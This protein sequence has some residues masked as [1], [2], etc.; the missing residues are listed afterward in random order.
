MANIKKFNVPNGLSTGSGDGLRE[1][2]DKEGNVYIPES[3]LDELNSSGL[4][5]Q[6]LSSTGTGAKWKYPIVTNVL[7][8]TKDGND[9]NSGTSLQNAKATIKS[10]LEVATSGTLIKVSAGNYAED[11][12]LIIPEQVSII[13]DSLREVSV[14]PLNPADLFY[15]N[16]GS[17]ISDM[18]FVSSLPNSYAIFAFNPNDPPYINQ[19]PYI[20][21]CTNFI[22]GS[23][24]L[25]VDGAHCLGQLKSMVVDS[26]T[27]YNQDG[28]GAQ[29]LNEGYAQLVSMFTICCDKAIECLSGGGCDLTNSN[30]S[31]GNYGLIADGVSELKYTGTVVDNQSE[32]N[33][34]IN[35]NIASVAT[36]IVDAIYAKE[37]GLLT[38]T[39]AIDH[40]LQ[41]GMD[42]ELRDLTFNCTS[43][44]STSSQDFPSGAYGYEF[45]VYSVI[46]PTEFT[47]RV[48]KSDIDHSYVPNTGNVKLKKIKPFDGQSLYINDLYYQVD[49]INISYGGSGYTA[50]PTIT[51]SPPE[52]T[53]GITATAIAEISNGEIV[54]I[55]TLSSGRGYSSTPPQI[56]IDPP[57]DGDGPIVAITMSPSYFLVAGSTEISEDNYSVTLK[58]EIPFAVSENDLV[59]VHKQTRLLAS[60]HSFEYV[61]SG[62]T[63]DT[64]LPRNGGESIQ[65]NEITMS[66][67]GSV[68]YT[69]TDQS[70]NF[71]IGD[72]VV[73]DQALGLISGDAYNRSL[74]S[75]V[76]PFIL[77]LGA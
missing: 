57:E 7:F 35:V 53:W 3:L 36:N 21:N 73:I 42:I 15:V 63:I 37:T 46:S 76:T 45:R 54:S 24:G 23:I 11:N 66:N 39:T 60:G 5:G 31:M 19:S 56:T 64:A 51:I 22:R 58:D 12:P 27:Q 55:S 14:S 10:A 34:S 30:S 9:S 1:I 13:G 32:E 40:N 52:E 48:G 72:G 4:P 65:E 49:K 59:Y 62:T 43:N 70:G 25:R 6:F 8:V 47:V 61:G 41:E 2:I 44:G 77:A 67:G 18:S 75:S 28:I 33:N 20:Q 38:V 68:I 74:F 17:Y 69:S 50:P 16:N 71:R 26:Y 29:I